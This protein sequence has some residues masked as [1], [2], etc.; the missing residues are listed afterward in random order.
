MKLWMFLVQNKVLGFKQR[1]RGGGKGII[2][3]YSRLYIDIFFSLYRLTG[4]RTSL[5]ESRRSSRPSPRSSNRPSPRCPATKHT[6]TPTLYCGDHQ[7]H[8]GA[9]QLHC[10]AEAELLVLV[11]LLQLHTNFSYLFL[12]K[13]K[14][15]RPILQ[16]EIS[17]L[18]FL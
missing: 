5:L 7:L 17:V 3:R 4:L 13:K 6:H 14:M 15:F 9:H 1:E 11:L 18:K 16:S 10:G 2:Q 8:C 12:S